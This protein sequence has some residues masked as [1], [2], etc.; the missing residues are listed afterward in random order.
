MVSDARPLVL[1]T[2]ADAAPAAGGPSQASKPAAAGSSS[3]L[4]P[5]EGSQPPWAP[6]S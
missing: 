4:L 1:V 2:E 6:S 3:L 5:G